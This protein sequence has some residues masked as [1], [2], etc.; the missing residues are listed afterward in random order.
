MEK[1]DVIEV[2]SSLIR[3]GVYHWDL[4]NDEITPNALS[5]RNIRIAKTL[6]KKIGVKVFNMNRCICID[7]ENRKKLKKYIIGDCNLLSS[8]NNIEFVS[9]NYKKKYWY[10]VDMANNDIYIFQSY[11]EASIFFAVSQTTLNDWAEKRTNGYLLNGIKKIT[12]IK[13]TGGKYKKRLLIKR[14]DD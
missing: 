4:D 11:L 9:N 1:F 8:K 2:V 3:D 14:R 7:S 13:Y 12:K 6:Y 10:K 5:I